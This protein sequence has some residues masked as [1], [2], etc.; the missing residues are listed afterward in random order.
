MIQSAINFYINPNMAYVAGS[1]SEVRH[2]AEM[3][4]SLQLDLPSAFSI[5]ATGI[6]I[7]KLDHDSDRRCII[8]EY[9]RNSQ[10]RH[11]D[12]RMKKIWRVDFLIFILSQLHYT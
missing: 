12:L 10:S 11:I 3:I 4:N 7:R 9:F 5:L 6:D 8:E 2:L 1:N